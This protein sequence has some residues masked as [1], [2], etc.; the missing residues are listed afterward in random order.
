VVVA[1]ALVIDAQTLWDQINL[2][3]HH[4]APREAWLHGHI[5]SQ[6]VIGADETRW[7]MMRDKGRDE[8]PSNWQVWAIACPTAMRFGA[9]A[10]TAMVDGDDAYVSRTKRA[11]VDSAALEGLATV[12]RLQRAP[13][14]V[15]CGGARVGLPTRLSGRSHGACCAGGDGWHSFTGL[16]ADEETADAPPRDPPLRR[17]RPLPH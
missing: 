9:Y 8:G 1:T 12:W 2:L 7:R 16:Y 4:L 5:V 11:P 17:T 6:P 13:R 15:P 14:S 3:A 10:G